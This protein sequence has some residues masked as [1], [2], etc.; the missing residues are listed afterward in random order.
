MDVID[1]VSCIKAEINNV[2]TLLRL[3]TK[4]SGNQRYLNSIQAK[5]EE[6]LV[7]QFRSLNEYLEGLFN[8][9]DIDCV[10]FRND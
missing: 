4:W 10:R 3:N 6:S 8:I 1:T 9:S 5:E 7:N 2:T